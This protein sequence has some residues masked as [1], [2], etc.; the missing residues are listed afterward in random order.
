MAPNAK[1]LI[2]SFFV[3]IIFFSVH[4]A[5]VLGIT[6]SI[7]S[8]LPTREKTEKKG[9]CK[10]NL[11]YAESDSTHSQYSSPV[12]ELNLIVMLTLSYICSLK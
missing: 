5:A 4:S 11:L 1:I 6:A 7:R 9:R 12:E 2:N 8:K 3:E 10:V